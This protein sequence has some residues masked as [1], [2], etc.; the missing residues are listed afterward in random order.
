M[1][2]LAG[3]AA[4]LTGASRGLG[5]ALAR[6]FWEAGA[7]LLLAARSAPA[8]EAVAAGLPPRAGQRAVIHAADLGD[9]AAPA[10]LAA[11]AHEHF[12]DL[13]ILV[14]NAAI[15]GPIGRAWDTDW[16]AWQAALRVNLLAPVALCR[17][18]APRMRARGGG[19]IINLSGGGAAGPRPGF[20]AYAASKAALVRFTETLAAE[21]DGSG[22]DVNAVAPGMLN[23][24][25]QAAVLRAG[26]EQAGEGEVAQAGRAA[27]GEAQALD[28]A[29]R[30]CVFLASPR[31][32]GLSGRLIS[33]AWDDWERLPERLDAVR[34]S[35]VYTLRRITPQD[36]GLAWE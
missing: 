28:R 8:L 16:D 11:A 17:L 31:S 30:L 4:L 10:R 35:D 24:R 13:H 14:N 25:M 29:A 1:T 3:R 15:V 27:E 9:P 23:T 36:R 26:P 22:V 34:A 33:A 2:P 21:L 18:V 5:A 12:P 7:S 19:K 6:A 32:D 20:S